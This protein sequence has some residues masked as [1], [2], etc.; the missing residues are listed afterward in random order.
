MK[1]VCR[2][3]VSA[4]KGFTLIELMVAVAVVAILA[5][6][7]YPAYTQHVLKANRSS[8]QSVMMNAASKQEQYFLDNRSYASSIN[9]LVTIPSD[10]AS[11]YD[12]TTN[13]LATTPPGYQVRATPK[14]A[15]LADTKCGE[16]TLSHD[17][18]KAKSGTGTVAECWQ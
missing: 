11:R 5:A 9:E 7:A 10:V 15:Q 12:I 18:S 6:V 17:G 16:L 1:S 13:T 4:S 8:A 14:S 3:Q 2:L